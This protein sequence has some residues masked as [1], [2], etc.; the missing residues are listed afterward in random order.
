MTTASPT[1]QLVED[2]ASVYFGAI[3]AATKRGVE[4][5]DAGERGDASQVT[6]TGR[7]AAR[8]ASAQPRS[9]ARQ[10][11][12][13]GAHPLAAAAPDADPEQPL[14]PLAA[15]RRRRRRVPRGE[16]RRDPWWPCPTSRFRQPRRERPAGSAP[17][18]R[19]WGFGQGDPPG[20]DDVPE[21]T[22][23]R[24]DRAE[25][26]DRHSGRPGRGPSTNSTVTCRPPP[27][28]LRRTWRW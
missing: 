4:I 19:Y 9:T 1:E 25:R 28:C 20:P 6:L 26:P 18:H 15:H 2:V 17:I 8:A 3:G 14:V 24:C 16:E 27:T 11:R 7:L 10:H 13:G 21:R 12:R 22:A 23:G 5:D